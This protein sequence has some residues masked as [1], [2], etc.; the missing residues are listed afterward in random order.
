VKPLDASER[1]FLAC[2]ERLRSPAWSELRQEPVDKGAVGEWWRRFEA[3]AE[4][5]AGQC[6]KQEAD[7]TAAMCKIM[8]FDGT[9][10]STYLDAIVGAV[11]RDMKFCDE[12]YCDPAP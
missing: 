3:V 12:T 5:T 6:Q 4:A 9:S 1:K 2:V 11:L 7:A 10:C 8:R